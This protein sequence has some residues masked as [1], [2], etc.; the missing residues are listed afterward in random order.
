MHE[1]EAY[2]WYYSMSP[3]LKMEQTQQRDEVAHMQI[4]CCGI[5][6][7]INHLALLG[8]FSQLF[9]ALGRVGQSQHGYKWTTYLETCEIKPLCSRSLKTSVLK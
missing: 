3:K 6:T 5:N 4:F 7:E 9:W 2:H 1:L 8:R